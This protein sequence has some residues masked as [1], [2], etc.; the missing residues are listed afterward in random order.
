MKQFFKFMFASMLGTILTLLLLF[1][2]LVGIIA[3]AM[4]FTKSTVEISDKSVL[5]VTFAQ[6]IP[7]RSTDDPFSNFNPASFESMEVTGLKDIMDNLEKAARDNKI[8]GIY[9]EVS[10]VPASAATVEELRNALLKFKESGKWIIAYG[11]MIDQQAY[12]LASVADRIY[13]HP[14]GFFLFKGINGEVAFLKG[15]LDKLGIEAQVIR[16]G[17]FKA[18]VEPLIQDKMSEANKEQVKTYISALWN[19]MVDGIADRRNLT[20]DELN[21]LANQLSL[22][23]PGDA[24][25]A[26][27]VDG[28]RYMDEL[29]DEL[30][31]SAGIE[32]SKDLKLIKLPKYLKAVDPQEKKIAKDKIAVIYAEG[33]IVSGKGT[34]GNVGSE[35]FAKAIRKARE[36]EKVKAIVLR[37]NSPG[38][39]GLASE[40]IHREIILAKKAKPV[41][42]SFGGVAASGGYYIACGADSIIASPNT[43]TGSIGV[44]GVI[45]NMEKFFNQ[46]LGL[47]FDRVMTNDHADFVGV[48]RPMNETEKAVLLK[49]V[50]DMYD[51]FIGHVSEGRGIEKAMVDSIGQGRVWAGTDALRIGLIDKFG[52]LD[53]AIRMAAGMAGITEYRISELPEV[54]DPF[55]K[56][57]EMFGSQARTKALQQELGYF[58]PYYTS[59]KTLT[60]MQGVQARMLMDIQ[61]K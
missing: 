42:A 37:V 10:S 58:Y 57:M 21:S 43:I 39:D 5:H 61:V 44:F 33:D 6:A 11:E 54:K 28:L 16:H 49:Q 17:K 3:A 26:G 60:T 52:G 12:Y 27:L 22:T 41:V 48:N 30:A 1:F 20:Q 36:D 55:E 50:E 14:E 29:L 13:M 31:D 46:K 32:A 25:E 56:F 4:S 2:I 24:V 18:A 47:T 7:D 19:Q 53:D 40:V 45:P 8:K 15:T 34:D 9:F 59:I 35:R 51:D 38:G 23:D